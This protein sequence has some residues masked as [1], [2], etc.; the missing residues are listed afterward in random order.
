MSN[1][2]VSPTR[3]ELFVSAGGEQQ[4][5]LAL[6]NHT[7]KSA[8]FLLGAEDLGSASAQQDDPVLLGNSA[9]SYSL[10]DYILS[11]DSSVTL[12]D[13]ETR[14]VPFV[15]RVPAGVTKPGLYGAV[16]IELSGSSAREAVPGAI[17]RSRLAVPVLVRT[18]EKPDVSGH[19]IDFDTINGTHVLWS[20]KVILKVAYQN[21]GNVHIEPTG[22]V[23]LSNFYGQQ[24]SNERVGPIVILPMSVRS[25]TLSVSSGYMPG[26]FTALL[27][28]EDG[29]GGHHEE[30]SLTLWILPWQTLLAVLVVFVIFILWRKVK[31]L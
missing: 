22:L 10:K 14:S 26:R 6:T 4:F 7:G 1:F 24:V 17:L 27:Q 8:T 25:Q 19:L 9:G 21:D 3:A 30:Q 13:G 29:F 11:T 15:V 5:S 2:Q 28:I 12:A 18:V 23:S 16:T 31:K 20:G